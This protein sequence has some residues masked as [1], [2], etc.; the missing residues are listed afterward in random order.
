[1]A[2]DSLSTKSLLMKM[3][4]PIKKFQRKRDIVTYS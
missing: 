2:R 4:D 3:A 1:M